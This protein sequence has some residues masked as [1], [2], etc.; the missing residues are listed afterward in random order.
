MPA[1][2]SFPAAAR[3]DGHGTDLPAP[4]CS[5]H[6]GLTLVRYSVKMNVVPEPSD[7]CA[8]TISLSGSSRPG[9]SDAIAGSFHRVISPKNIPAT[10][11]AVSLRP[12]SG[13]SG[14]LYASTTPPIDSGMWSVP[15]ASSS[16]DALIGLS[17]A[18]KL[19]VFSMC[20]LMP[21]PLPMDW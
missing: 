5:S 19:T 20:C 18:A 13:T 7:L 8:V 16:S 6:L 21:P 14:M 2:P 4:I 11:S 3:P 15:C 9:F 10:A 1:T 12:F 17:E